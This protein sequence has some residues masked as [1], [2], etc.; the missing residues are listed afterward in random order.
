MKMKRGLQEFA[1]VL[2][3]APGPSVRRS[4]RRMA[5]V[6]D[7]NPMVARF[8][9]ERMARR[10][11]VY[12]NPKSILAS[13]VRMPHPVG[14]VIGEGVRIG[15]RVSI[16]QNVTLGGARVGDWQAGNYPEV[17]DDSTIFAG[18]VIVG[19]VKIGRHAVVAANAVVTKDVP[20]HA[21][22]AG[23]PARV[24]RVADPE[25]PVVPAS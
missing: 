19:A 8:I 4:L 3:G 16:Y 10:F 25:G 9:S 18:A 11:G 20:D 1:G 12:I 7:R 15:E 23:V 21:T 17:G 24:V 22:V 6:R 14:I 2:I 5:K 13:T